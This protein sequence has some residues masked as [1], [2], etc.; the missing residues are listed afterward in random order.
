MLTIK[1]LDCSIGL[2]TFLFFK[3]ILTG[4]NK[5]GISW[6]AAKS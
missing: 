4:E 6:S 5:R 1:A 2:I 3:T